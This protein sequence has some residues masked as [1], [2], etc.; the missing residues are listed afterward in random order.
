MYIL[1][2]IRRIIYAS[3]VWTVFG[4]LMHEP[5]LSIFNGNFDDETMLKNL[6]KITVADPPLLDT[7]KEGETRYGQSKL[8]C[9]QMAKDIVNNTSKSIICVRFGGVNIHNQPAKEWRRC[10]WLSHRDL[11]SF[12]D[13]ALQAPLHISGTYFA[14][15]NNHRGW[16]DLEDAKRDLGYV[17]QDGAEKL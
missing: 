11:C 4:Y 6:R 13:K 2:G 7:R 10:N 16:L 1:A 8:I 3:S 12:I 15:S 14:L 5:Y 9:E 17:P